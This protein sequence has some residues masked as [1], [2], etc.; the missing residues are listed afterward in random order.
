[1]I[2]KADSLKN[3]FE[4]KI[5]VSIFPKKTSNYDCL[6]HSFLVDINCIKCHSYESIKYLEFCVVSSIS[7][8]ILEQ[9]QREGDSIEMYF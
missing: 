3:A 5:D 8:E 6:L 1:M 2:F 9:R 4:L 7:N